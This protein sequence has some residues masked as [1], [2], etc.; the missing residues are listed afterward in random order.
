LFDDIDMIGIALL[1]L[2]L[3][4]F[5]PAEKD[6]YKSK[7]K[8]LIDSSLEQLKGRRI[9]FLAGDPGPLAIAAVIYNDLGDQKAVQ[10]YIDK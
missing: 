6:N 10:K 4:T 5:F 7:A 1:Y 9:S 3:A 2:R 8:T